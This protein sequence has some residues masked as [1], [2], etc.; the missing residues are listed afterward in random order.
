MSLNPIIQEYRLGADSGD[1]WG[2]SMALFFGIAAVLH[3]RDPAMV[4]IKWQYRPPL[5]RWDDPRDE[6]D[7]WISYYANYQLLQ[8]G[9]VIERY[10]H[11]LRRHGCDY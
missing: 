4:P 11:L 9:S 7:Q 3:S 1:P 2:S 8:A 10:T 5:H 6:Q